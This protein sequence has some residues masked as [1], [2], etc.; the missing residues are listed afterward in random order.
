[1]KSSEFSISMIVSAFL[2]A[3]K[4]QLGVDLG[5]KSTSESPDG[6]TP[7]TE[8][9]TPATDPIPSIYPTPSLSFVAGLTQQRQFS[10]CNGEQPFDCNIFSGTNFQT[11]R[12]SNI[13][14]FET[15]K[16]TEA[17]QV[18]AAPKKRRPAQSL[19]DNLIAKN[20]VNASKSF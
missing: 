6:C 16:S 12:Q 11:R 5:H 1:M 7:I 18:V 15:P 19:M 13:S 3:K 9:V 20:N 2:F 4:I 10:V 8:P 17:T 14:Q